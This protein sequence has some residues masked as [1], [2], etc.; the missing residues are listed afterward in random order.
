ME[1]RY[2]FGGDDHVFVEIDEEMS[3][4]AFF[5]SLSMTSAVRESRIR[6]VTEICPANA[7]YQIR[8]DPGLISPDDM[9]AEL[10]RLE[11]AAARERPNAVHPHHRSSGLLQRSLDT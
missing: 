5:K 9:M 1:T 11:S 4:D 3:L 6:G 7:S 2:S 10:K 8:F